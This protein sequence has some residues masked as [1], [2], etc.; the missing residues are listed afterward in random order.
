METE[1]I[2]LLFNTLLLGVVGFFLRDLH[3][4]FKKWAGKTQDLHTEL[5]RTATT[6][7]LHQEQTQGDIEELRRR[8]N[9][10]Q[11]EPDFSPGPNNPNPQG[12]KFWSLL[13]RLFGTVVEDFLQR[14]ENPLS[15]LFGKP[16]P[17]PCPPFPF[18]EAP[19]LEPLR[20]PFPSPVFG[21]PGPKSS[22]DFADME[23]PLQGSIQWDFT[24]KKPKKT[25]KG[26][27]KPAYKSH[28]HAL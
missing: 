10:I 8:L 11:E 19:D 28:R 9:E 6:Q 15:A 20:P 12:D 5:T 27:K 21:K 25:R 16:A 13:E 3:S 7:K 22:F 1:H 2:F 26:P 4:Q 14:G 18:R 24:G 23:I 17:D